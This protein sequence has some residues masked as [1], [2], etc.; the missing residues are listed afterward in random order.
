MS[1]GRIFCIT[2]K[3]TYQALEHNLRL[4]EKKKAKNAIHNSVVY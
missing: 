2:M 3:I 1:R 4:E